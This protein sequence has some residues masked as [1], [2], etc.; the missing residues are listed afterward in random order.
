MNVSM[1]SCPVCNCKSFD[2]LFQKESDRNEIY[3]VVRCRQCELV[4]VNPQPDEDTLKPYYEESYFDK[5]TDRGYDNY[6]S[7]EIKKQINSI[8]FKNLYDLGFLSFESV[9]LS[10]PRPNCL[11]I[12]CAA[13]YFVELMQERGWNAEGIEISKKAAAYGIEKLNLKIH[14]SDFL[15]TDLHKEYDLITL[16]ASIEHL[17]KPHEVMAKA[18]SSL[19]RGGRM[20]LS[21]CRY[22]ILA[23]MQGP[24]WR[25]MNVPE[26]L[27]YF[28]ISN[29]K[30]LAKKSGFRIVKIVSYGSGFTARKNASVLYK[31]SKRIADPCVK[32]FNIG[33]MMAVHLEKII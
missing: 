9:T 8:Y 17:R 2:F 7:D 27:F 26:H 30:H 23:R 20:I 11:D 29:M 16:W 22:G 3:S 18:S 24:S 12:G 13:G 32:F 1:I 15:L 4:M 14:N 31:F 19:R 28:S 25:Y 6:F 21:T 5:R 10:G 33:D